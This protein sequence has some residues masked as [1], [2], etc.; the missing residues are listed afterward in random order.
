[1]L[2]KTR[3]L[4]ICAV[5]IC[6][7]LFCGHYAV[8]DRHAFVAAGSGVELPDFFS[9][10]IDC[11]VVDNGG[12]DV[13]KAKNYIFETAGE[14]SLRSRL[15]GVVPLKDVAVSVYEEK[16]VV[17][18]GQSVGLIMNTCGVIVVGY[19]AVTDEKG[20]AVYPGKDAGIL[21]GDCI[22]SVEGNEVSGDEDAMKLMDRCGSDGTLT[23]EILRG[24]EH[25]IKTVKTC[26]C[27]E[28]GRYRIGLYVR[29][30][31]GGVGTMTYYDP[32]T[33]R[34]G[35]LGHGVKEAEEDEGG[36]SGRI[37]PASIS[38]IRSA[39]EGST[40]EKIG[41]FHPGAFD[42]VIDS[43]GVYGVFGTLKEPLINEE[44]PLIK[45]ASP[46]EI[47]KGAAQIITV[48]E[49]EAPEWFDVE[50]TAVD[51]DDE[52][53]KGLSLTIVDEKLLRRT[54]GI[55]QGMSGS[56][57]LQNGKL[58][59]AVTYVMVNEPQKGYGCLIQYMLREGEAA[60]CGSE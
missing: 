9:V 58:I 37:L 49:G 54:G 26:L 41:Y 48:L 32:A 12:S 30:N 52:E 25:Q 17:P 40:G 7:L 35:A 47:K 8:S 14:Y 1:M 42:G 36:V 50:I 19:S 45:T 6:S 16:E 33:G 59:G 55:I 13:G 3:R 44:L 57:I 11:D 39:G 27:K 15:F 24:G 51:P 18:G 60:G 38:G 5:M 56:P 46:A 53:G 22:T 34:F 10:F 43:I 20:R 2:K 28:T 21:L 23:L 31:T 4:L 29:D